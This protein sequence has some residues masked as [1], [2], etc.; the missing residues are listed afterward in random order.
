VKSSAL[1]LEKIGITRYENRNI[2]QAM[3]KR[4][5]INQIIDNAILQC[6]CR[7]A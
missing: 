2:L 3:I 1:D 7:L 6:S 4:G 5:K